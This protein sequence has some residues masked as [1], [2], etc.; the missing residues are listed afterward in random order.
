M[1]KKLLSFLD[2]KTKIQ[3]LFIQIMF[4]LT[5]F[6][7]FLNLNFLLAFLTSIFTKNKSE[8]T[9]PLFEFLNF[10]IFNSLTTS[11]IGVYLIFIFF[12]TSSFILISNYIIYYFSNYLTAKLTNTYFSR[13]LNANYFYI[14][15]KGTSGIIHDVSN[16]IP[17]ISEGIIFPS[18]Q[19]INKVLL[20]IAILIFLFSNFFQITIKL[21]IISILMITIFY[22]VLKKYFYSF[23][24]K[25][26]K[27]Q[28]A[29]IKSFYE[30]FTNIKSIKIFNIE[31]FFLQKVLKNLNIYSKYQSLGYLFGRIPKFFFELLAISITTFVLI[32]FSI[33]NDENI[34]NL[35]PIIGT[36]AFVGYRLLPIFQELFTSLSMIKNSQ[37]AANKIL[38]KNL[39]KEKDFVYKYKKKLKLKINNLRIKNLYFKYP[40]KRKFLFKNFSSSFFRNKI[41][42]ISGTSGVG[43]TTLVNILSGYIIPQK[44]NFDLNGKEVENSQYYNII[45]EKFSYNEQRPN[46]FDTSI[47]QNV[48]LNFNLKKYNKK[49]YEKCLKDASL[50][51]F[52]SEKFK[53]GNVGDAANKLSGGQIQRILLA[54]ALYHQKEVLIFDEPTNFLDDKNKIKVIQSIKNIKKNKIII[55]LSHDEK[56]LNISDKIIKLY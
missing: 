5:T 7:E 19:I 51:E 42:T 22:L 17:K 26:S 13:T 39:F 29:V 52:I 32:F 27:S 34:E 53:K 37:F 35:I 41:T 56:I 46:L 14:L 4:I 8:N 21:L 9:I 11:E 36:F 16:Q 55:I 12:L 49:L 3:I 24:V 48:T 45:K 6:L 50:D 54:R 43:K 47:K 20:L 31:K 25:V 2:K 23:G 15:N 33:N 44:V 40:R 18:L 38:N 30:T 10:N 28:S 1:L